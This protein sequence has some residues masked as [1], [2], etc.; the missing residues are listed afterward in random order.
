M[1]AR[2]E[3]KALHDYVEEA[4]TLNVFERLH[5]EINTEI[6][7]LHARMGQAAYAD[8]VDNIAGQISAHQ[9]VLRKLQVCKCVDTREGVSD[10]AIANS[11]GVDY[12][13]CR[14]EF[15]PK[16]R[17]R[18]RKPFGDFLRAISLTG[19][20]INRH[21]EYR[22]MEVCG[23]FMAFPRDAQR[24]FERTLLKNVGIVD[25]VMDNHVFDV[26]DEQSGKRIYLEFSGDF[27]YVGDAIQ[28]FTEDEA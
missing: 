12:V 1:P 4:T 18:K 15:H 24:E 21:H 23:D 19:M 6:T 13:E 11:I 26:T 16:H 8:E 20:R 10:N 22:T 28:S 3:W 7:F 2:N 25:V 9:F 5:D 14:Q 17:A 27:M